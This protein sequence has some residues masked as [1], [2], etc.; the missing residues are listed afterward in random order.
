MILRSR[1]NIGR[2]SRIIETPK[3]S[4]DAGYLRLLK[5]A[6]NGFIPRPRPLKEI[7]WLDADTVEKLNKA[8]IKN[9]RH[10]FEAACG[11]AA[12]LASNIGI[13]HQDT[14]ELLSISDLCRIQWVSPNFARAL[15]AAGAENA[16]AVAAANPETLFET[17]KKANRNAESYKGMVGLRDINRL[18]AAAQYVP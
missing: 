8:G 14:R 13:S 17:I 6:I 10:L 16:G 15:V 2:V 5:R 1:P 7:Y 18:V 4:V 11:G 12:E 9:T 3:A